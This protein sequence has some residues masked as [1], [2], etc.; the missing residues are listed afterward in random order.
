MQY[1][2]NGSRLR[3]ASLPVRVTFTG[4][5]LFVLIGFGTNFAIDAWNTGLT[6]DGIAHY[7]RG[8]EPPPGSMEDLHYP[9]ELRELVE[10]L[11]FHIYLI[12]MLLLVVTHV[13][14]MTRFSQAAMVGSTV[15]LWL[16]LLGELGGP[17]LVRYAGPGFA[18]VKLGSSLA[19]HGALLLQSAGSLWDAWATPEP[20]PPSAELPVDVEL[21]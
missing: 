6:P 11:H 16:A 13:F 4:F 15:V 20:A 12:P 19:F 5:L 18:F 17:F 1:F 2:I 14:F 3:N 21:G 8:F 9:K 7:Y 10:N